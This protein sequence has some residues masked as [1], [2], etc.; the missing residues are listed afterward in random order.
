MCLVYK[1]EKVS[2][3]PAFSDGDEG[4]G[5]DHCPPDSSRL[6]DTDAGEFY[7]KLKRAVPRVNSLDAEAMQISGISSASSLKVPLF[8]LENCM[9]KHPPLC[10]SL[11]PFS[12]FSKITTSFG[13]PHFDGLLCEFMLFPQ[14]FSFIIF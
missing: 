3:S 2:S 14:S 12:T 9:V 11:K 5:D 6:A 4:S 10:L 13:D 8:C 1:M 7:Q